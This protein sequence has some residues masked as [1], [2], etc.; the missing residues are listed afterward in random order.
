MVAV[1][2]I[3]VDDVICACLP[4]YEEFLEQVKTAFEWGSAWEKDDFIF[5]G[6]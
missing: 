4:G 1:L 2:G 5:T 3:H 6:Q